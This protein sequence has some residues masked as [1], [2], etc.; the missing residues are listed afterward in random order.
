MDL[1][2]LLLVL[3]VL[4]P[5]LLP[6]PLPPPPPNFIRG[7]SALISHVSRALLLQLA[8]IQS[9]CP[10]VLCLIKIEQESS[11]CPAVVSRDHVVCLATE[12]AERRGIAEIAR[13]R[14]Y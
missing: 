5:L 8:N 12:H 7:P 10:A 3:L 2:L 1:L 6:P 11:G 14:R 13:A 9:G 4:L